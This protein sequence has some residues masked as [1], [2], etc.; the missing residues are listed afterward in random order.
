MILGSDHRRCAAGQAKDGLLVERLDVYAAGRCLDPNLSP[1]HDSVK[2]TFVPQRD[3]IRA[4]DA[5]ALGRQQEVE[6]LRHGQ[7]R[8]SPN[9]RD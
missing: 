2:P 7:K 3:E 9:R 4:E 5:E 1:G 8:H 6:R